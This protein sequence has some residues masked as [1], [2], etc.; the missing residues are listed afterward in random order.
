MA[1]PQL[2][3]PAAQMNV[4]NAMDARHPKSEASPPL[5]KSRVLK[6]LDNFKQGR[7]EA[8]KSQEIAAAMESGRRRKLMS[9]RKNV[10]EDLKSLTGKA[11][12]NELLKASWMFK[13][14]L[15]GLYANM[16]GITERTKNVSGE[17]KIKKLQARKIKVESLKITLEIAKTMAAL[18][19]AGRK[20]VS[21]CFGWAWT[22]I[23]PILLIILSIFI[24]P[25]I[26]MRQFFFPSPMSLC[27]Q[28]QKKIKQV[29]KILETLDKQLKAAKKEAVLRRQL[30][31]IN[32]LLA[33]KRINA[34]L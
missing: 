13:F 34:L 4:A 9:A 21:W 16:V 27:G 32:Q 22:G 5:P 26:A 2:L 1:E 31:Q 29:N 11:E 28:I 3:D 6:N 17:M 33:A 8:K 19:D 14:L 30:V 7:E 18:M 15:P 12:E 23:I 20:L 24:I 25:L 10:M